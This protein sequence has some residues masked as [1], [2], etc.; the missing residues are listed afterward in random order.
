MSFPMLRL[1]DGFDH[2][3]PDL[4]D[5]VKQLQELLV[6]QGFELTP[7]GLFGEQTESIVK[8]FQKKK[9]LDDDGIVGQITWAALLGTPLPQDSEE[10]PTTYSKNNPSL[11]KQLT[12]SVKYADIIDDVSK[13]SGIS[14]ALIWGIGSRESN[15]GLALKPVGPA[16]TGDF[17]KRSSRKP[18]RPGPLPPDGGGFGRGLMQIDYDAHDFARGNDWKDP[19]KSLLFGMKVLTDNRNFIAKKTSLQGEALLRAAVAAYNC[20]AGNVLKAIQKGRDV[21]FFTAGRDYSKDTLNRAG[22]YMLHQKD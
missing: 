17:A 5:E 20:G 3:T 4:Q 19:K 9:N 21:D 12:E 16:G 8:E 15:W 7:D 18:F 11:L 10:F 2:T 14:N 1:F 6:K 13:S 22:F